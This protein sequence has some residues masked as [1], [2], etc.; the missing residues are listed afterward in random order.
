[1]L[2]EFRSNTRT[3]RSEIKEVPIEA[4]YSIRK[5]ERYYTL[6]KRVYEIMK[7]ELRNEEVDKQVILQ[8]TI[9]VVNNIARLNSLVLT[10]LVFRVYLRVSYDSV[11]S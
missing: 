11:L 6:L 4:Y 7:K 8:M 5:V 10:L 9:K 3:I 1:M 2:I